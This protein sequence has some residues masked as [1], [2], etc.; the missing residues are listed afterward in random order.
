[1]TQTAEQEKQGHSDEF[2]SRHFNT[3]GTRRKTSKGRVEGSET[4]N[5]TQKAKQ[6][7]LSSAQQSGQKQ[8]SRHKMHGKEDQKGHGEGV[9]NRKP[10]IKGW[11]QKTRA[12]VKGAGT[13]STNHRMAEWTGES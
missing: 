2:R 5:L 8:K 12:K 1:M 7:R 9:S 10:N 4:E 11:D 6:I 3:Q 13:D